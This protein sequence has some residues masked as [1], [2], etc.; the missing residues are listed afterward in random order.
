VIPGLADVQIAGQLYL[1]VS[2]ARSCS[3]LD[4]IRDNASCRRRAD[5]IRLAPAGGSGL[6]RR[7]RDLVACGQF[8][9]PMLAA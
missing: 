4:R 6:T 7:L 3:H 1:S 9:L 5:L 2:P 8:C